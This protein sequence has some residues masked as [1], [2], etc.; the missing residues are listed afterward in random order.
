VGFDFDKPLLIAG[1]AMGL[2]SSLH[3]LGMCSG[4]ATSLS[5]AAIST[6]GHS[7][8]HL[9]WITVLTNAGR[10]TG[11]VL[12]GAA[13]GGIGTIAFGALDRSVF[14]LV[15]RWGAAVSLGWIGLS[16]IGVLPL[17]TLF[18][19][20]SDT[21]S[22]CVA[23]IARG[24]RLSS[25]A[26][27]FLAG[28]AW[29]FLPCAMVYAALFYA[30]LSGAWASGA[31]VMFGFGLGTSLPVMAAGFGLPLLSQRASAGWL[32]TAVGVVIVLLGVGSVLVPVAA[33]PDWCRLG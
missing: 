23:A 4:I 5:F 22:D 2:S 16:M 15:L 7:S 13:V 21:V 24:F 25:A 8:R 20:F 10:I 17:P 30:M 28:C 12:A 1:L 29:G 3:C 18:H 19:C 6:S 9:C 26:G 14:H 11:Y 33:M 31:V 32:R 27:L